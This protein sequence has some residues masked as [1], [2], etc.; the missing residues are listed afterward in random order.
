MVPVVEGHPGPAAHQAH[1]AHHGLA[2]RN[3]CGGVGGMPGGKEAWSG[4][5]APHGHGMLSP[6]PLPRRPSQAQERK[7]HLTG[8]PSGRLRRAQL[9]SKEHF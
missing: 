4:A 3:A 2:A 6:A 1:G 5:R 8:V 7:P 9:K